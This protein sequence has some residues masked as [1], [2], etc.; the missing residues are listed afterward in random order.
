LTFALFIKRRWWLGIVGLFV[1][2]V[3]LKL[4]GS[5]IGVWQKVMKEPGP[6]RG[7]LLFKPEEVRADEWSHITP[8]MIGQARHS[9]PFPIENESL[10]GGRSPLLM[11]VPVA[12]YTTFFRPQLWG[13]FVLNLERAFA[14][15]W[16]C[17]IF[18]LL[19]AVA[20]FLRQLGIKSGLIVAFGTSWVFFSSF[21]QWWFSSPAMLP[22]ML[23]CWAMLTGCAL[24]FFRAQ[25]SLY[26]AV[27]LIGFVFFGVNFVLCLYPGFQVPLLYVSVAIV[28]G[29]WLRHRSSDEWWTRQ[30]ML[31]LATALAL[32]AIILIPFWLDVL[33]TLKSLAQTSYPGVIRNTGGGLGLSGLFSGVLGFFES[34]ERIPFDYVNI[35]EA[36][37]FYPLWLL[38]IVALA[39]GKYTNRVPVSPLIVALAIAIF[40]LAVYCVLP[41]PG[42]LARVSLLGLAPIKRL[43]VGVGVANILLCCAFFDCY[44]RPL[45][46]RSGIVGLATGLVTLGAGIRW[47][48]PFTDDQGLSILLVAINALIVGLFFWV[49]AGRWFLAT[50]ASLVVLNG[51][52]INPVLR[53]LSPILESQA[54]REVDKLRA[55]DPQLRWVL[56]EDASCAQLVKATGASVF[57]GI[58][59]LPDLDFMREVDPAGRY[60]WIYNRFAYINVGLP[61][62][63][64]EIAFLLTAANSYLFTLAPEHPALRKNGYGYLIFPRP[65]LNPTLH[66][67]IFVEKI[68]PSDLYIYKLESQ[69]QQ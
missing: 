64:G 21:V 25:T 67:Y 14:F 37:N 44:P 36:S 8:S 56:Y 58:K 32:L 48:H 51:I 38:A 33:P 54:F 39:I 26:L 61:E 40:T 57:N 60:A 20:W 3:S 53:G 62:S 10:G 7:L 13:F 43:L 41:M 9:P 31:L 55:A 46:P 6:V 17:K 1:L 34:E 63:T 66:G 23:A 12:Y 22:E 28:I 19:L 45:F 65:W 35:C 68:D 4:N 50:F 69:T 52:A 27:A 11:S 24:N 49:G 47:F 59:I 5:S 2:C 18:G 42:W 16:C 30:G 29:I 15:Y